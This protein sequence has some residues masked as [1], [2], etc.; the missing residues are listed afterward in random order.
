MTYGYVRVSTKE[1]N[2]DRQLTAMREKGVQRIYCDKQ[3][4]KDFD[5]P[6]FRKLMRKLKKGDVFVIQSIDRLGRNYT[7]ILEQWRVL[8][9]EKNVDIIVLDM[10]VLDTTGG[11]DLTARLIADIVLQLLSYVAETERD[12]ILKRQREGI[13]EAR[14]RGV[15]MGR[16]SLPRPAVYNSLASSYRQGKLSAREAAAALG[17]SHTSFLNWVSKDTEENKAQTEIL[18]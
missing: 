3:S 10:P 12:F 5:R 4:G 15:R 9:K 1:Q 11:T 13:I 7:E 2:E 17:I 6:Q 14:K 16:P 18:L 8:T